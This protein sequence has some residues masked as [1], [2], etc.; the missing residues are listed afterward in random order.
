MKQHLFMNIVCKTSEEL[1]HMAVLADTLL[2]QSE[3]VGQTGFQAT[4]WGEESLSEEKTNEASAVLN[5]RLSP[6]AVGEAG[7][8]FAQLVDKLQKQK[9]VDA[10][11]CQ[12]FV[13]KKCQV[14]ACEKSAQCPVC[15]GAMEEGRGVR[16]TASYPGSLV[17]A[18]L[19]GA[20]LLPS[21][22]SVGASGKKKL[23]LGSMLW[24]ERKEKSLPAPWLKGL[25]NSLRL[26][27]FGD[28]GRFTKNWEGSWI[29]ASADYWNDYLEPWCWLLQQMDVALPGAF[30]AF[31]P[32]NVVDRK[33][34]PV[35]PL[36]LAK[37]YG[38]DAI[39]YALLSLK[40]VAGESV[41]NEDSIIQRINQDL[42]NELGNLVSRT[43]S[44]VERY[45]DGLIPRPDVLTRTTADLELREVA[46]VTPSTVRHHVVLLEPHMAVA[47]VRRLIAQTNRFIETTTPWQLVTGAANQE[48][49]QTVLYSL[50]EALRFL[51]SAL[52]PLLPETSVII[53]EQLGLPQGWSSARDEYSEKWGGLRP[54]TRIMPMPPLFPRI[55]PGKSSHEE[56]MVLRDELKR[57]RMVVARVVSAEVVPG[58]RRMVQLVLYDG[59]QRRQVLAPIGGAYRASD[60]TGKKVIMLANLRPVTQQG[61][62]NE[63]EVLLLDTE[64]GMQKLIEVEL[65][66]AEGS[67]IRAISD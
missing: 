44:M 11:D 66:V 49:L 21:D 53:Y 4:C 9:L 45:S 51:G 46:L 23:V 58:S 22:V 62:V 50:C 54:G 3:G 28:E 7:Q 18:E 29:F 5:L 12:G 10:E 56:D 24:N 8:V 47:A 27:E 48:R 1:P 36:L 61:L 16:W 26:A 65:S 31:Q 40:P 20:N 42:A 43:I 32:P 2:R 64:D 14:F 55:V 33:E 67:S 41:L 15:Q 52:E 60:L 38:T 35:S 25:L 39:R 34:Q 37:N 6:A 30:V 63:G 19:P 59:T 57:V 13:C 17:F